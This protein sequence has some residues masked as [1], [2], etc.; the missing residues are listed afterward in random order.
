M[1]VH[2]IY[3]YIFYERELCDDISRKLL[4][5]V[6]ICRFHLFN[7]LFHLDL[8]ILE[9][10]AIEY[11]S[12]EMFKWFQRK[13]KRKVKRIE[14]FKQSRFKWLREYHEIVH[15]LNELI[16]LIFGWSCCVVILFNFAILLTDLNWMYRHTYI[17]SVVFN[18]SESFNMDFCHV[19][20]LINSKTI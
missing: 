16:N 19:S 11:E 2:H 17:K 14:Q 13:S 10:K 5:L 4:I 9:L 8:I 6:I 7:Y 1:P 15:K 18:T 20:H 12:I 3:I